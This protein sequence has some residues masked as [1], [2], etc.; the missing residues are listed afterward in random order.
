[1]GL[2][3]PPAAPARSTA[4]TAASQL[5]RPSPVRAWLFSVLLSPARTQ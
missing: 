4:R 2:N 3:S 5:G 1:M